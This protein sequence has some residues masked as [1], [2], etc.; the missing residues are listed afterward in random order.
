MTAFDRAWRVVKSD[1][2]IDDDAQCPKCGITLPICRC[3][4]EQALQMEKIT[5]W[6]KET[7]NAGVPYEDWDWD[8]EELTVFGEMGHRA[9]GKEKYTLA[10]LIEAGVLGKDGF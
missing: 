4:H 3:A 7:G 2:D 10:D 5:R 6:M 8:G 1:D 9:D